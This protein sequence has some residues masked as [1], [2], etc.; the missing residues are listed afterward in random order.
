MKTVGQILK[1]ARLEKNYSIDQ[2][3]SLTKIDGK[4]IQSIE[5]DRYDQLPSETFAKG[6]IRNL[7]LRLER[8]PDDLVAIFRRDFKIPTPGQGKILRT[9][10]HFIPTSFFTSQVALFS[11]GII[12]FVGYL[13]FQFRAI[14]TPP[15]LEIL[16]PISGSVLV[17]PVDIEGNTSPDSTVTINQDTTTKPDPSGHFLTRINLPVGDTNLE[18]KSTNRFSRTST[19]TIPITVVSQ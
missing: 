16:R 14:L 13:I 9:H 6:F 5:E 12:V 4:Y 2:L 11:L 3:S 19:Q 7:S 17:S 8:N 15:R 18:I 1:K 10:H